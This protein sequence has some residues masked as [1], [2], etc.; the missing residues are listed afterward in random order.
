MGRD[1]KKANNDAS[2]SSSPSSASSSSPSLSVGK[3]VEVPTPSSAVDEEPHLD[4]QAA[5]K[6]KDV[7][8]NNTTVPD[9][10]T[11]E[12][13][14]FEVYTTS[15]YVD[16][17]DFV[18]TPFT[19]E[20]VIMFGMLVCAESFLFA[21]TALPLR[22]LIAFASLITKGFRKLPLVQKLD[23]FK[24]VLIMLGFIAIQN[25]DLTT[26]AAY[27]KES[28]LKLKMIW[29]CLEFLDKV[30]VAYGDNILGSVAYILA[31]MGDS[32]ASG[33][34]PVKRT[35]LFYFFLAGGY[36]A[37]HSVV[38]LLQLSV[39][40]M[41]I[42]SGNNSLLALLILVQFAE[43]KGNALKKTSADD[44]KTI[45]WE[46][47]VER[48]QLIVFV[49]ILVLRVFDE[50]WSLNWTH[51]FPLIII[52]LSE[53][54]VDW[55]KHSSICNV[56]SLSPFI[57]TQCS[58]ELG[59]QI[60]ASKR[61]F[62]SDR[63]YNA[64][65]KL[66]LWTLP[67]TI[68]VMKFIVDCFDSPLWVKFLQNTYGGV[69]A[70]YPGFAGVIGLFFVAAVVRQ[71]LYASL[72]SVSKWRFLL[73]VDKWLRLDITLNDKKEEGTPAQGEKKAEEKKKK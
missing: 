27:V 40:E 65:H 20:R 21:F 39:M 56:S 55:L 11:D 6:A 49:V 73:G 64:T 3:P 19:L 14:S 18:F 71:I 37:A 42:L 36:V 16:N 60:L 17:V 26:L 35:T 45:V 54:S 50:G 70:T 58:N 28:T 46:D 34:M 5:K 53:V 29:G 47:I 9:Y 2:T 66:G 43:M 22:F 12:T 63:T 32:S 67:L 1:K 30:M 59:E 31:S 15:S 4:K 24:A 13:P 57:Y 41:A 23:L 10:V 61:K 44:L 38:L 51:A 69:V 52:Y 33:K 62:F 72:K 25:I 68:V 48:F 8:R 7:L